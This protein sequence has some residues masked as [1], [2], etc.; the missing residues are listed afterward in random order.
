M[1][2][3]YL[4][5][6]CG[7]LSSK[8]RTAASDSLKA[9]KKIEAATQVGVN[10]QQYGQ[11]VIE[12]K[13][14]VNEALSVLSDGEL[15]KELDATMDAYADAGQAWGVKISGHGILKQNEEPGKTLISKYSLKAEVPSIAKSLGAIV[16]SDDALQ[17][18]WGEARKHLERASSLLKE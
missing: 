4:L 18:I 16:H 3:V 14:Q 8:Q 5:A 15:K 10:Y 6:A 12:A 9:L 11:L 2:S 17:V 1:F 13:A 7:G